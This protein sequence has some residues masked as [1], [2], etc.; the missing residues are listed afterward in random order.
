VAFVPEAH[1]PL[2]ENQDNSLAIAKGNKPMRSIPVR[3]HSSTVRQ[4][5]FN[6]TLALYLPNLEWK[7]PWKLLYNPEK[8]EYWLTAPRTK[9]LIINGL[10]RKQTLEKVTLR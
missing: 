8:D 10:D 4:Y 3:W 6:D 1:I 7:G 5:Q 9:Y 2:Y